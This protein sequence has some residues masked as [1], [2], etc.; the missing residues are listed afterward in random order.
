MSVLWPSLF[1]TQP[2]PHA[3]GA[4]DISLPVNDDADAIGNPILGASKSGQ[5]LVDELPRALRAA[6]WPGVNDT[7]YNRILIEPSLL[8]MG[9][10]LSNQTRPIAV[11][12]G[13]LTRKNLES[14]QRINDAGIDFAQPV[15]APYLMRPLE[16][17]TYVLNI[18][19]DGPAVINA[20]YVWTID[21]VKYGADVTGRRVQIWPFGPSWDSP[22]TESLEWL[23]NVLRSFSG[24]EQRRAM[25][26]KPRRTF[27]YTF[28]TF[29]MQS[30]RLESLLWG[31]QNRIYALPVWTD[32]SRL[33]EAASQGDEVILLDTRNY[34]FK[35]G[36]LAI[37][38]G[39]S[40]RMEVVEIESL[41]VDRIN[42]ARP[43]EAGWPKGTRVMPVV[44]GH[45]PT[46]VP[47]MRYTSQAVVGTLTFE[48]D[49]TQTN[50]YLPDSVPAVSY[51]DREVLM[52]QPNWKGGLNNSFEYAFD[53]LDQL[54]GAITYDTTEQFPRIVRDY[55]WL[56]NGRQQIADFR[57]M[58][59]RRMGQQRS[60]YV[61]SWHDDM[62][63]GRTIGAADI[64]ISIDPNTDFRLLV[65]VDPARDRLMIRLK[66]G[67]YYFRRVVGVS[68]DSSFTILTIDQALGREIT[69][70]MVKTIHFLMC[71]RLAT[72]RVDIVWQNGRVATV[73]TT[74][75]TILE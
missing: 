66:D 5:G 18:K 27:S 54:T 29:R 33:Q 59:G 37:L 44:L 42:T 14:V 28:K 52:R 68:A 51:N 50:P 36:D 38:F 21:G 46:S 4:F 3:D 10:L 1:F 2:G 13:Y 25:R 61:P 35:A 57:S 24:K 12:N 34:S 49:P 63:V 16:T 19:T 8:E 60:L 17:L 26:S 48:T 39:D 41:A 43:L 73:G 58:L 65:G 47:L 71:S 62:R 45:L 40:E 22:V 20:S 7:F 70:D 31:W 72:D 67:S 75:T 56:L 53:R 30:A 32:R 15:D 64:G 11:W 23:T 9:N 74:I 55:S 69:V 6:V